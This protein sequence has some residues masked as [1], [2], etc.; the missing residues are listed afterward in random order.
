MWN[1]KEGA[2]L[3]ISFQNSELIFPH[4]PWNTWKQESQASNY[5]AFK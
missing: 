3:P 2:L 5:S 1:L 4:I